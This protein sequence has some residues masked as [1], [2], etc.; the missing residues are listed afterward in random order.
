MMAYL[1]SF[2]QI[3][4]PLIEPLMAA[5]LVCSDETDFRRRNREGTG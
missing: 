3:A 1:L 5:A 2:S 4:M